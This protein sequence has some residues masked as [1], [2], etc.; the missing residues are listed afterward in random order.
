MVKPV[1]T[2]AAALA[3]YA[4]LRQEVA[5][6]N[7]ARNAIFTLQFTVSGALFSFAISGADR[8]G[9]LLIIPFTSYLLYVRF[10]GQYYGIM[11]VQ[12]YITDTL[13]PRVRGGLG[14][15]YWL[16]SEGIFAP[17]VPNR[18][19]ALI[20]SASSLVIPF[21]VV[22][23]VA[24]LWSIPFTFFPPMHRPVIQTVG[25]AGAWLL[26]VLFTGLGTYVGLRLNKAWRLSKRGAALRAVGNA[27]K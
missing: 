22:A 4:T 11:N 23:T 14:W 1:D 17:T 16:Q 20:L 24:L 6:R 8:L 15:D 5:Q 2:E 21:Q 13:S 25:L 3:E 9:F 26:G 12:K 7:S 18:V 27:T 19:I 10:V